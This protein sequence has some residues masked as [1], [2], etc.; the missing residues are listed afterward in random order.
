MMSSGV[1]RTRA[2][3]LLF[4]LGITG[5]EAAAQSCPGMATPYPDVAQA[6]FRQI[7]DHRSRFGLAP[8]LRN[9]CLDGI[10]QAH[11]N[12]MAAG[13]AAFDHSD[14]VQ[15]LDRLRFPWR[16]YGEN[17]AW[18]EGG[19]DPAASAVREW[20]QSPVHRSTLEGA[21]ALTGIGVAAR[22]PRRFYF[23]QIFV[24]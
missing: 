22:P 1:A 15:S 3:A 4:A 10:A 14:L 6:I 13:T 7:Q 21:Y 17:I 24:R 16:R 18:D 2:A 19:R 20:L 11:S 23:T 8:L 5:G 9:Q 12:A